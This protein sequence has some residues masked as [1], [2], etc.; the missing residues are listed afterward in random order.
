MTKYYVTYKGH[1]KET[2][3]IK[4]G[5]FQRDV[6]T[7]INKRQYDFLKGK[8]SFITEIEEEVKKKSPVKKTRKIKSI[9]QGDTNG[10]L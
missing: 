9:I 1:H 5:I 4:Y 2:M 8:R 3:V 6:R 10:S 7:E